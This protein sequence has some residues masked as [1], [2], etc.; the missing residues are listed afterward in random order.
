MLDNLRLRVGTNN[1]RIY[2]LIEPGETKTLVGNFQMP[3]SAATC[4]ALT[5]QDIVYDEYCYNPITY[6]NQTPSPTP[7]PS[8]VPTVSN[9]YRNH[10]IAL[11]DASYN[12]DGN[13]TDRETVTLL[14]TGNQPDVDLSKLSLRFGS[15][16][17]QLNG[18][19]IGSGL[20]LVT[21]NF[22]MPNSKATCIDLMEADFIFDTYC[23]DPSST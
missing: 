12:P 15:T 22:Q 7:T 16:R 2:G 4:V 19:L 13:D 8:P 17:R 18:Y 6:T 1:K 11:I 5:Y 14:M 10:H 21:G 23:Y 20:K 3:N 9:L